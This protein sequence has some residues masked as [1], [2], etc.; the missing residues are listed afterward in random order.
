MKTALQMARQRFPRKVPEFLPFGG[1]LD[2]VTPPMFLKPGRLRRAQNY[3]CDVNGG[4]TRVMGYE[5]FDG[6]T[7]PSSANYAII[8]VTISGAF[9]ANDTITGVTSAATAVVVAVVTSENPNY[10]VVTKVVGTFVSGET[11]NVA[12]APQG[13]TSSAATV[14]GASSALLHAQYKNLAA[15]EY[16]DDIAAPTGSGNLRG[17]FRFNGVTYVLRNNAGGTAGV[18]YKSTSTGWSVVALGRQ[19]QFST[20]NLSI[21]E[22]TVLTGATSGATGTITRQALRS[23]TYGGANAAGIFTF[24]TVTGTFQNGENLQTG[25]V[26][27]A[28]AVGADAAITLAPSG[29]LEA[30][31]HNFGGSVNSRRVYGCDGVSMGFEFDGTVFVPIATGMTTDTPS[32]VGVNKNQLFFSFGASAQHAAPG[33]PYVWSVVT[34]ASELAMGDTIT[35]F[36][37]QPGGESTGAFAIFTRNV[38]KILYG[39]GVST[40]NLVTYRDELGAYAYTIQD[41][42]DTLFLDDLGVTTFQAAQSF[43]NFAHAAISDLIRPWMNVQRT[44]AVASC[45]VRNKNQYR[46]FFSDSYVLY[47]TMIGRKVAGLMPVLLSHTPTCSW[48]AE[49][50]D[51]S[52]TVW[53]GAS[54]GMCYQMEKGTSFDGGA[55]E[56]YLHLVYNFSKSPD[57]LKDYKKCVLEITG[58]GYAAWLFSYSLGYGTSD[59]SQPDTVTTVTSLS[60]LNWDAA[61]VVWDALFWD[62]QSLIPESL[63]MEGAAENMSIILQGSSDY[64][65]AIRFSGARVHYIPRRIIH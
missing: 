52:E 62:G 34:G 9:A 35:G 22:G 3:E 40:W 57:I 20:G 58:E 27:R 47:M 56:H 39:S 24:A 32:H 26:T 60:P 18:L 12:A 51:G 63:P 23:G 48:S 55:I 41:L 64:H 50:S 1:G 4:Y 16:R 59:I 17:G 43:G 10:L 46:L 25:G 29:Q 14:D 53:F 8:N 54:N 37:S 49:E 42:A 61:G 38:T 2:L 19:L 31:I 11:L 13:V 36:K 15:D 5:R 21:S 28:V 30:I 45:I 33:T 65:S 7:S 6:R 44:K